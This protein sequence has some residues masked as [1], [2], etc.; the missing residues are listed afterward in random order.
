MIAAAVAPSRVAGAPE[1]APLLE[2]LGAA[3]AVVGR[4]RWEVR[5]E[6][7][8]FRE[9]FPPGTGADDLGARL[10]EMDL[11]RARDR[12]ARGRPFRYDIE[13]PLNPRPLPVQVEIRGAPDGDAVVVEVTSIS[14]QKEAEYMLDSYSRM[15]ERQARELERERERAEKLLL[16]IMPRAVYEELREFGTTTPQSF[17]SA[18]VLM[19]DFVDFTEMAIAQH[20]G[21]LIAELNDVFTSFDRIVDHFHC[22]RLK[23]IGDAYM[24]VGGVP[25]PDP[26]HA[27]H[28]AHAAL[29]IRRFLERRNESSPLKLRCRMGIGVGPAIGAIVGIQKYAYDLFGPAVNMAARL[30]SEAEPMQI[31]VCGATRERLRD[32]FVLRSVGEAELK[33]FGVREL[34]SLEDVARPGR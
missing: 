5:Y 18:S 10:P 14:R 23:T 3:V 16:N 9:W 22:E 29:K 7:A 26:D 2:A 19:L 34:F 11:E 27:S 20:P 12:L 30:E 15:M 31:L 1:P 25:A 17:S 13:V 8:R 24:A 32:D 21:A 6:N 28:L 33:G 4:E